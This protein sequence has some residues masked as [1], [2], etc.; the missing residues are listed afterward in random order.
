MDKPTFLK[1]ANSIIE[2]TPTQDKVM[3][4]QQVDKKQ[5]STG[6]Q[7]TKYYSQFMKQHEKTLNSTV[8]TKK[9]INQKQ[10]GTNTNIKLMYDK[11][12]ELLEEHGHAEKYTTPKFMDMD[13][14]EV[15]DASWQY[16]KNR[17]QKVIHQNNKWENARQVPPYAYDLGDQVVMVQQPQHCKYMASLNSKGRLCQKNGTF[18]LTCIPKGAGT[19]YETCN[20]RN[21]HP[22]TA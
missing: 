12:Y 8:A 18:C 7:S 10:W 20:I 6:K 3:R 16:I 19:I 13:G 1:V 17:Q 5:W 15:A 4:W 11:I 21:I 14:N 2:G 22:C 9:D